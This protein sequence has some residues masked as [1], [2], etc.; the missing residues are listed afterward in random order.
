MK[1]IHAIAAMALLY[2]SSLPGCGSH[3]QDSGDET[4]RRIIREIELE[5]N[6]LIR[7]ATKGHDGY[8]LPSAITDL[9]SSVTTPEMLADLYRRCSLGSDNVTRMMSEAGLL[10][11]PDPYWIVMGMIL[12]RLASMESPDSIRAL[13]RLL[14]DPELHFDG[15]SALNIRASLMAHGSAAIPHL[16]TI[17]DSESN[18]EFAQ[19][20][21]CD[22]ENDAPL[23]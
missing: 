16:K 9:V 3:E 18:W 21:I 20:V 7:N 23:F 13:V 15:E 17:P 5:S 8:S 14:V 12:E 1:V 4:V 11:C 6:S 19:R 22:I 10:T 2:C